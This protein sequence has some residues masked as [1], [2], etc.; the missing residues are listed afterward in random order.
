MLGFAGE[1]REV[2]ARCRRPV[3][4]CYCR[5]LTSIETKTRVVLLQHPRERDMPIG[6]A[7]MASL[8]LPRSELHVGVHWDSSPEL[9]RALS[10]PERP[11]VLLYPGE[12]A[13]DVAAHPPPGP[14]TLV[15]V[16]G[17]W[18]QARKLVRANRELA[19]LPRYAF[20]PPAPS[21]Y[22]IRKEPDADYVST[23]EALVLVLGVL[24]GEPARFEA[25]LAP[26]RAMID[27]QLAC[28]RRFAS[29]RRRHAK[30]PP[31]RGPRLPAALRR[32]DDVVCVA[33]E[34]NAW[35][36][37]ARAGTPGYPDELVVWA[38]H[39]P[40]TGEAIELR[41]A[42][43]QPLSPGTPSHVGL[44]AEAL[45]AGGSLRGVFEAW[46]AFVRPTDI[47]CSWGRYATS[48]FVETGGRLPAARLDLRQV[49]RLQANGKVGTIE[50]YFASLGVEAA[51]VPGPGRALERLS[52]VVSIT[53][54]FHE[55]A[56]GDAARLV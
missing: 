27:A 44:S 2:C 40:A 8:C 42:P 19:A 34:A 14:V 16:D 37:R 29:A 36:Y 53:R 10:D 20:S 6:T 33:G 7:R 21:E 23:L 50:G 25:L 22:R 49:A 48:L 30:K 35:P 5:H 31:P 39:R 56:E 45:R 55:L 46:D 1:P 15:V 18:W 13:I 54:R 28:Q 4:V 32:W 26:F 9:A 51:P 3:S 38:A 41:A 47:V 24:E 17:T 12:G 11:A 52:K 43:T